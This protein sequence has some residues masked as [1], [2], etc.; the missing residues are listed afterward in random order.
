M[1]TEYQIDIINRL[2]LERD[3]HNLSQKDIADKL[4]ISYGFLGRIES[5]KQ[6][7]KYNLAQIRQLCEIYG[8]RLSELFMP[9][10]HLDGEDLINGLVNAIIEYENL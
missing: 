7:G 9:D 5:P 10:S 8:I 1:K 4:G 2:K 6:E 3:K